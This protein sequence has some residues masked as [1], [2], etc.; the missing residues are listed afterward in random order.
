M[1][2][3]RK[4][5]STIEKLYLAFNQLRPPFA[6]QVVVEGVGRLQETHL[7]AAMAR[8]AEANPGAC[9]RV[10]GHLGGR[11]WVP[12]PAPR[13][14]VVSRS[15]WDGRS[16]D[17]APFLDRPLDPA[18]GPTCEL[19]VIETPARTFLVFRSLHAVMDGLGTLFWA[20]DVMRALRGEPLVGH[21]SAM[22]DTGFAAGL[23][24]APLLLPA[25][26]ALHPCG[27]ADAQSSGNDFVWRR[28]T[29]E[30]PADQPLVAALAVALAAC[31]RQHGE[32]AVR[33]N[34]PADLRFFHKDERSTGNVIGTLFVE[35]AADVTAAALAAEIKTR[36][37][38]REHARFPANYER[39]RWLPLGAL[40]ATVQRGFAHEHERG[41]YT[42][43]GTL[44][45]LGAVEPVTLAAPGFAPVTTFW[46]PP[47]AD[48]TCFVSAN[49][50]GAHLELLLAMP[51]VLSTRGR[52]EAL[53][54]TLT[55]VAS[56]RG[57]ASAGAGGSEARIAR[58]RGGQRGDDV[59]D[60][61]E[62]P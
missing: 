33:F 47:M 14:T 35:V 61:G 18:Q 29:V 43:S 60:E 11:A 42:L 50:F 2:R 51:R 40:V 28:V 25:A 32:G 59:V 19:Q 1:G 53:L 27:R 15:S 38:A 21:P 30:D 8:A 37:R 46:I 23:N 41:R 17:D 5:V 49:R 58:D 36:L 10:S 44:S 62:R 4:P 26:D 48:Q 39:L 52:F 16:G 34:V 24:D 9:L 12:G 22:T 56:G 20:Q 13:L 54:G 7:R 55:E 57:R 3:F 45:Y 31:A 6:N